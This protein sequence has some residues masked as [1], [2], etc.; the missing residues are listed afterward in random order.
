MKLLEWSIMSVSVSGGSPLGGQWSAQAEWH[1]LW[2]PK[3]R[4]SE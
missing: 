2:I 4:H 3:C 1:F